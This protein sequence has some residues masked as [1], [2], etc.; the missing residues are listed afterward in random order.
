M[1]SVIISRSEHSVSRQ[2]IHPDALK[3][4]YRLVRK[5]FTAYLVG[6]GVRDLLLGRTPKDFDVSTNATPSQ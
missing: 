1:T 5:G 3:V 2:N 4:M 6:G